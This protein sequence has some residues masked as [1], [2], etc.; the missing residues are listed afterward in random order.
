MGQTYVQGEFQETVTNP[1]ELVVASRAQSVL[2]G[3]VHAT[4]CAHSMLLSLLDCPIM[5]SGECPRGQHAC[6]WLLGGLT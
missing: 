5:H 1:I 4:P 6:K 2:V 3:R